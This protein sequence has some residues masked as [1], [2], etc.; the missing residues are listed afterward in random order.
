MVYWHWIVRVCRITTDVASDPKLT[1]RFR[2]GFQRDK[3]RS[4]RA[5]EVDTI[6]ENVWWRD[7][8]KRSTRSCLSHIPFEN[9]RRRDTSSSTKIHGSTAA[10]TESADNEHSWR[11]ITMVVGDCGADSGFDGMNYSRLGWIL[12]DRWQWNFGMRQLVSPSKQSDR[13]A[14]IASVISKCCHTLARRIGQK[15]NIIERATAASESG[16]VRDPICLLLVAVPELDVSVMQRNWKF[17]SGISRAHK[18]VCIVEKLTQQDHLQSS[19]ESSFKPTMI[20][21]FGALTQEPSGTNVAP[22]ASNS[23]SSNMRSELLSTFT[24]YPASSRAF[25]VDGVTIRSQ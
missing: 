14:G 19:A 24:V 25:V 5:G 22:T 7:F 9:W 12:G 8:E 13:G 20:W 16:K 6:D 1:T 18:S 15:F 21:S 11:L 23:S 17:G 10:T 3:W 4:R 2:Q